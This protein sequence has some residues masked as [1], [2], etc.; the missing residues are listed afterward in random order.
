MSAAWVLMLGLAAGY[1]ANKRMVLQ[2]AVDMA[3]RELNSKTEP[4]PNLPSHSHGT[5]ISEDA[6]L[7]R[8]VVTDH[9]QDYHHPRR[10]I[11][12]CSS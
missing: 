4:D 3:D 1:L 6:T 12:Q 9:L 5:Q 7:H 10:L 8:E 2:S 11:T